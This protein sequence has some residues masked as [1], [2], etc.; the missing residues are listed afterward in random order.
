MPSQCRWKSWVWLVGSLKKSLPIALEGSTGIPQCGYSQDF[1]FS[2][3]ICMLQPLKRK[4]VLI[5]S[6]KKRAYSWNTCAILCV[7]RHSFLYVSL[8]NVIYLQ[9]V[10]SIS[11]KSVSTDNILTAL[12][13]LYSVITSESQHI[14]YIVQY[15]QRLFRCSQF[16]KLFCIMLMYVQFQSF[17]SLVLALYQDYIIAYIIFSIHS[18]EIFLRLWWKLRKLN[19]SHPFSLDVIRGW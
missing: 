4:T 5:F 13:K 17:L 1:V 8:H 12:Y 11:P 3:V 14:C 9:Q 18:K 2:L 16:L 6:E 7:H 10:Y 19:L 15:V